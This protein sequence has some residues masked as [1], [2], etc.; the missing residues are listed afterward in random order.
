MSWSGDQGGV[1]ELIPPTGWRD[2][3]SAR[4]GLDWSEI[5]SRLEVTWKAGELGHINLREA[6]RQ[7]ATA[8]G[9]SDAA[10]ARFMNDM[11][12]EY[13]GT[14]NLE[15]ADYFKSLR[16]R[17]RT[18]VLSNGFVGAREREQHAYGFEDICDVIVYSQEEGFKKPDAHI[19]EIVLRQLDV[20]PH[21]ALF[22]DDVESCVDGARRV[23]MDAVQFIGNEQA[24]AD[25]E[26][27]FNSPPT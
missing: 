13:L 16:P 20:R 19:Y 18:G 21:E 9:L 8:L 6:E 10:L 3:W 24:I 1:L 15:L 23:G 2:I 14:L 27:Y 12:T 4:L 26:S 7:I 11:W 25:L 17:F 5:D 22:L